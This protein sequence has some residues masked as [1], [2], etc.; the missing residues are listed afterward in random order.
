MKQLVFLVLALAAIFFFWDT[1]VI[2]PL[3]LLVVFFHEASHALAAI[4]TGGEVIELV[5]NKMQGGHVISRGGSRFIVASAGYLGS[6]AWGMACYLVA[7]KT[8]QDKA[9]LFIFGLFIVLV[10]LVF[11]PI[12][13]NLFGFVFSIVTGGV[14]MALGLKASEK[15][16]DVV[17]QIIGLTS[18]M[19]A[20]L[21]IY[22]DTIQRSQM[23]SDARTLA[24]EFFGT[25]LM[26]GGLWFLLSI[27]LIG[28]ALW[29][30]V[31]KEIAAA[32]TRVEQD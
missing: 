4:L 3:K 14:L 9:A 12:L 21:D 8:R 13:N 15:A 23:R 20:P 17:L 31:K 25:T 22:S 6:L 24:E 5:V 26:W 32:G 11:I 1:I 27:F 7:V 30:S 29:I 28:F 18:M 16:N 19:Y 2:Y 10:A